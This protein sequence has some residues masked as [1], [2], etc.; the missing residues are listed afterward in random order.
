[1]APSILEEKIQVLITDDH[2]LFREGLATLLKPFPDIEI[3][4]SVSSG[5]EAISAAALLKPDV[6]LMDILMNGMS[7][8]EATRWIKEQNAS[9]KVILIS[10]EVTKEFVT[11]GIECGINGYLNK[12]VDADT[13]VAALRTVQRG[14][15]AF[16]PAV[17]MLIFEDVYRKNNQIRKSIAHL[18]AQ[19]NLTRREHEILA[20]VVSGAKNREVAE[21]LSISVK[22][23]ETH[24]T[25]IL[26]KLGVKNTT[27]LI[28]YALQNNL[29][30]LD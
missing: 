18:P 27:G 5:E 21:I 25:N 6:V 28:K 30:D 13:L 20:H 10:S 17:R 19:D 14:G 22:T 1:M 12:D 8:I 29:V 26:S 15:R 7:G 11:I 9:I 4:G 24:K 3:V 2:T 16:D 23:V